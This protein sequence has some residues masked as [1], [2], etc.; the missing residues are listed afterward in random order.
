MTKDSPKIS[1]ILSIYNVENYIEECMASLLSQTFTDYEI[2]MVDDGS[3]DKCPGICDE[4][5]KKDRRIIV[6]HQENAGVSNARNKALDVATGDYVA[7]VDA[8]DWIEQEMLGTM[9]QV[10]LEQ[11]VD[12]V[13]CGVNYC[14][15]DG[16]YIQSGLSRNA[17]LDRE[18]ILSDLY[19][20]KLL[21]MLFDSPFHK[22]F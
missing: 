20:Q 22:Y 4:Y 7:F 1:I 13:I 6:I 21:Y 11:N 16:E 10:M 2:I 19:N 3:I 15:E 5:A 17:V 9:L 18:D 8:D 12:I 14:T